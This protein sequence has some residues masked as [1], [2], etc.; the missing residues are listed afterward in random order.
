MSAI[1]VQLPLGVLY[2][3]DHAVE[4][5]MSPDGANPAVEGIPFINEATYITPGTSGVNPCVTVPADPTEM[6]LK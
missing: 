3:L 5:D 2:R 4:F 1:N 6:F